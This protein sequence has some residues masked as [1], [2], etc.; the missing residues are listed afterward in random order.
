MGG[1]K[2]SQGI[3]EKIG[4]AGQSYSRKQQGFGVSLSWLLGGDSVNEYAQMCCVM[5]HLLLNHYGG[6]FVTSGNEK[7]LETH[8]TAFFTLMV[9]RK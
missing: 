2:S 6:L 4:G 7:Q 8:T 1:S 9:W 3:K 5:H